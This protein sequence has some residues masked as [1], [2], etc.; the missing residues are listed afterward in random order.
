MNELDHIH[1]Y[2]TGPN[3]EYSEWRNALMCVPMPVQG[4]SLGGPMLVHRTSL[5]APMLVQGTGLLPVA[6][7]P[8]LIQRM[9]GAPVPMQGTSLPPMAGAPVLCQGT[10]FPGAYMASPSWPMFMPS[11]LPQAEAL[12]HQKIK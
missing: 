6:S 9:S 2:E 10:P 3:S 1:H 7:V 8:M 5:G 11:L 4:T 12:K